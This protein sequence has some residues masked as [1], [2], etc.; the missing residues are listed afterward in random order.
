MTDHFAVLHQP[1]RPWLDP[2]QL[3][4]EYQRLTITQHPDRQEQ[5]NRLDFASINEAYRVLSNPR[6]RLN[7][8]LN[9]NNDANA[10]TAVPADMADLF[11]QAAA[12]VQ[13]IVGLL[14]KRDG[15]ASAL[16][17]SLVEAEMADHRERGNRLLQQLDTLYGTALEDLRRADQSWLKNPAEVID[18]LT[19]L[20]HRF[21]YLDRWIN[22]LKERQFQLSS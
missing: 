5:G 1:R 18:E 10:T 4:R 21:G 14:Q 16:S 19:R 9:L 3:K 2:D 20:A 8:L 7:H 22:Q 6:L 12:L 17:K 15:A 11:M 13:G